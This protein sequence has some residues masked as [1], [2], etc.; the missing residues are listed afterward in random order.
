MKTTTT[1]DDDDDEEECSCN[2]LSTFGLYIRPGSSRG[3]L[4]FIK[5]KY[6]QPVVEGMG[7]GGG[8]GWW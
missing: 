8:G 6:E 3:I 5:K 4:A 1:I 7:G 2:P